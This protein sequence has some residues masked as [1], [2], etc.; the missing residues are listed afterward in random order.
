MADKQTVLGRERDTPS[1]R[2]RREIVEHDDCRPG[3]GEPV[4]GGRR[5][6]WAIRR[7]PMDV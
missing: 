4:D 7:Q 6:S 3:R 5:E 1:R 2:A